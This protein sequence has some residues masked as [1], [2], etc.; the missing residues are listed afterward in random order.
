MILAA[1]S[2]IHIIG[3]VA[4]RVNCQG[5]SKAKRLMLGG[6]DAPLQTDLVPLTGLF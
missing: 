2:L 5:I 4:A 1:A 6:D 3:F